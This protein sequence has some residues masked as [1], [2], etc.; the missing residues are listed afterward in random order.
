MY[1]PHQSRADLHV[2]SKHSNR[3][4]EWFLRRIGAPE[5][6][7]EPRHIY[8]RAR[9]RGMNFVTISDHNSIA[10]ALE[11]ADLP[12]TFISDEVTTY[13][14]EDNCKVHVLALDIDEGQ[15]RMIQ[16]LRGSIYDLREYLVGEDILH[17]VAHPLYRVNN[18]LTIDHIEKLLL[19]FNRFEAINGAR[20]PRASELVSVV[21]R[22][23]T[24]ESIEGMA[25]R[26]GIEPLGP[27]PWEK[28]FTGGS[29]DHSGVY[30]ASAHTVTPHAEDLDEFLAYLR[31]GEHRE[32]GGSGSS[33]MM[34]HGLYHIAYSY[35]KDR[36]LHGEDGAQRTIVGQ[37]FQKLLEKTEQPATPAGFG[38][39]LRDAA[40]NFLVSRRMSKFSEVERALIEEFSALFSDD[41][42]RDV[43]S[44]PPNDRRTFHIACRISQTLGYSF[45]RRFEK[46]AREGRLME[47]VQTVASL[48]PVALSVAPYLAAFSTQHK[49]EDFIQEVARHF[50]A[51]AAL[52]ERSGR[53]AWVTDTFSDINGVARTIQALAAEARRGGRDLTVITCLDESPKTKVDLKNFR[54]VGTFHLPEY[55]S[56]LVSFPPFLEV[57]EYI[58]RQRFSEIIISTPG[59]MGLIALAAA[60]L[61]GLRTTGI[62]H[63]DFPLYVRY[64]TEDESIE[65]LTW[66]YMLWFYEQ[67][68]VVLAPSE[69]Y[70]KHLAHHGFDPTKLRVLVRGVDTKCFNPDRRDPNYWKAYAL[71]DRLTFL[72][73]G[74]VS[75]EKN[76]HLLIEA[77]EKLL[78][79][80]HQANLAVVGD[81]PQRAELQ[82]RYAGQPVTFTGFLEGEALV[83]A[84]ASA[85]V[86]VFPSVS[87]TFGNAVLEAQ[88]CGLPAIVADRG[89]PPEIV[90]S[91]DSGIVVDV[92][93]PDAL[94]EAMESL[95]VAPDR[96]AE[97]SCRA[98]QNA[99][100]RNWDKVLDALWN[101]GD[102]RTAGGNGQA[103]RTLNPPRE[104][105]PLTSAE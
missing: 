34:G 5:C 51:G 74:R 40:T 80:G 20:D 12:G 73:V 49:D 42:R 22:S 43:A 98:L 16:E 76:I 18:R 60:R 14:P 54:P 28:R 92:D 66:K 57:I 67:T 69:F 48:G 30:A 93:R 10:G 13:F 24:P 3:P 6:Y 52:R 2:H 17:S 78:Q 85:D 83:A 100:S 56:Q 37:L 15:F 95:A 58:E 53:K 105:V 55:Q 68:D 64:I 87:D 32:G 21:F 41:E 11:I 19:L 44:A 104:T 99:A 72:Y 47:S 86:M 61:L 84:Y 81:G 62:Y 88:A 103:I 59:P 36:F 7:V 25:A 96:R 97:L 33:V 91:H 23:L 70:R 9:A 65:D 71:D 63:T 29:D 46:Y 45:L 27:R 79:R 35:Y 1:A 38:H 82:Q 75:R 4:S 77:F 94:L 8:D 101:N 50:P 90:R 89:G 26:H 31:R 39:W 102:S